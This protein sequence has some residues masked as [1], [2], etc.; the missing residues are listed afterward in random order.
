MGLNVDGQLLRKNMLKAKVINYQTSEVQEKIL[1]PETEIRGECLIGRHPSCNLI[2]NSP[3]V[4]RVHGRIL[5]QEGNYYFSDLGSTDGS[6]INNEDI[7]VNQQR[8]LKRDDIIR[9]GEFVILIEAIDLN[10]VATV[11]LLQDKQA[12]QGNSAQIRQWQQGEITVRCVQVIEQTSDA[13]TFRFMAEPKVLF[14]YQPGQFVTLDLDINGKKVKRSY[15]IS[16]TP[17]RPHTLEITVKRVPSPADEPDIPPGLVSNWLHDNLKV[18]SLVKLSGPM[19][20]FTCVEQIDK[21]LLFISAGSGITPMMSMSQWIC[22]TAA[23][24]DM[25]FV[26][27]A[28]SPK[29]II[30]RQELELMAAEYPNFRLAVT[31]TR[32]EPG[33][34]WWGY[35][36]RLNEPMLQAIAS[37]FRD[38]TVYVCG[39]NPFM[40]AVKTLLESLDFPMQNYYAESFGGKKPSKAKAKTATS[41][42]RLVHNTEKDIS[43]AEVATNGHQ[44]RL[45]EV[46]SLPVTTSTVATTT[47]PKVVFAKSGKEVDCDGEDVILDIAEQEGV[48]MPSGCRMG[49]C[50]ACKQKLL[51][52]E[53]KYEGEPDALKESEREEG[54][55]L[56]CLAHPVGKV[57]I[58]A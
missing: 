35:T 53:V 16:S 33:Q 50:G 14:D 26:H 4:S 25:V 18:G 41:P 30:F 45:Q 43:L 52:G 31:M 2:L 37:D 40:E 7:L 15:S 54:L 36:G 56:T 39:P 29:D 49:A 12:V 9:V 19:G 46:A 6:R 32:Q 47:Q 8:L 3:E 28:R 10:G 38:R 20:K 1:T 22:D 44:T 17:S 34:A 13:K 24:T 5:F 55:I 23:N 51:E 48:D 11:P 58:S 27:S 21:K 42:L 57:V